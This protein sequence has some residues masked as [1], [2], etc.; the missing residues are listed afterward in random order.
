VSEDRPPDPATPATRSSPLLSIDPERFYRRLTILTFALLLNV[1]VIWLLQQFAAILQPL[2]IAVLLS[3]V[4]LPLRQYLT[5]HGVPARFAYILILALV[6]TTAF[7]VGQM[8]YSSIEELGRTWPHYER[9]LDQ[10][11]D[12]VREALPFHVAELEGQRVRDLLHVTSYDQIAA[13]LRA[14]IGTFL[15]FLSGFLVTALYLIFLVAE[16][17]SFHRRIELAFSKELATEVF[18]VMAT[19]NNSIARYLAVK[20]LIGLLTALGVMIVLALFR[21]PFVPLWGIL[22][23]LLNYIPYLG[24]ILAAVPPIALCV[25]EYSDRLWV[26]AFVALLIVGIQQ[27]LGNWVEPRM[28]G[29]RLNVSPLLIILALSFWAIVWGIVGMI[30]AIPLLVVLKIVLDQIPETKPLATLMSNPD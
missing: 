9:K 3:Y 24:S 12:R 28:L 13:P 1:L 18:S 27:F 15:G 20:T 7:F 22:I 21:V 29:T 6:L 26:P 17:A 2:L 23:F 25:L 16:R 5:A 10:L 4:I 11:L 30:L 8:V 14:L 19:I